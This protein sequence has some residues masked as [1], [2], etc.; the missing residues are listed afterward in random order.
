MARLRISALV[1]DVDALS[2]RLGNQLG[3]VPHL[4]DLHAELAAWLAEAR[5]LESQLEVQTGFL[6]QT[7][8]QRRLTES[9]GVTLRGRV[10]HGLRSHFGS[11]SKVLHEFAVRPLNGGGGRRK[12]AKPDQPAPEATPPPVEPGSSA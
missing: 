6:R 9:R 12:P 2:T 4:A 3:E 7:N 5:S 1:A 11:R 8:E 10:V